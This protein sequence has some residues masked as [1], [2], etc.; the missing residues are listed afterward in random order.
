MVKISSVKY[1]YI[2]FT[3]GRIE[4]RDNSQMSAEKQFFGRHFLGQWYQED[5]CKPCW[6]VWRVQKGI[7]D[8][9]LMDSLGKDVTAYTPV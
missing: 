4:S 8:G 1:P 3:A 5:V 6:N 7:L 9:D 2:Y